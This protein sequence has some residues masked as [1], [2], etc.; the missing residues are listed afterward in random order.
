M[1]VRCGNGNT[2]IGGLEWLPEDSKQDS[3]REVKGSHEFTGSRTFA[4]SIT[5]TVIDELP[6]GNMVVAGRSER[7][8]AGEETLTMLTGIVKS[9]FRSCH[10]ERNCKF[11]HATEVK[12]PFAHAASTGWGLSDHHAGLACKACH[13]D[14]SSFRTPR[15]ECT[16]CHIHWEVGSFDHASTGLTLDEDHVDLDGI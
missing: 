9:G 7:Q 11:C 2:F 13:G 4:D 6:N 14:P 16:S 8:I 3:T 10:G 5:V 1:T 12:P 15:T